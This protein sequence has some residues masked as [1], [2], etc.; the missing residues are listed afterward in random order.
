MGQSGK[1]GERNPNN[2]PNPRNGQSMVPYNPELKYT[3]GDFEQVLV[4]ARRAARTEL[5]QEMGISEWNAKSTPSSRWFAEGTEGRFMEMLDQERGDLCM[6]NHTD[7]ELAAEL[8]IYGNMDEYEK[9]RALLSGK[10]SSIA[11]LMAGKERIRWLSR[12][13]NSSL[14]SEQALVKELSAFKEKVWNHLVKEYGWCGPQILRVKALELLSADAVDELMLQYAAFQS[15]KLI[16]KD[17]VVLRDKDGIS[18]ITKGVQIDAEKVWAF[19]VDND[20]YAGYNP[21]ALRKQALEILPEYF[22]DAMMQPILTKLFNEGSIDK[23]GTRAGCL[24]S[25][26]PYTGPIFAGTIPEDAPDV[27]PANAIERILQAPTPDNIT[28][29]LDKEKP[30]VPPSA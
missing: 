7:D 10:A 20:T 26:L 28:Q 17:G 9:T 16:G 18:G 15:D 2:P 23:K 11:Y 27:K 1:K 30:D 12:H 5:L 6:G 22:V 13:L 3:Q 4:A 14:A 25:V 24:G 21:D 29:L 8:F 19:L